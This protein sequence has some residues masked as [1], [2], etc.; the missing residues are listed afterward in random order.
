MKKIYTFL[1]ALT[2]CTCAS[3]A[4]IVT[5]TPAILQESSKNVVLT[6]HADSPLGNQGLAG[7]PASAK[8]YAHI[9]AITNK[10]TST[11]DWKY[12]VADWTVNVDKAQLQYVSP[13]TWNLNI[14]DMR[15]YFGITDATEHVEKIALVFRTSDGNA[16]GKAFGG[17]DI[18]VDVH[19]EGYAMQFVSNATS[20]VVSTAT[21][22]NFTVYTTQAST[23]TLTCNGTTVKT[24]SN[25]TELTTPYTLSAKGS[26]EFKVTATNGSQTLTETKN[27]MFISPSPAGRYPN[28]SPKMGAVKNADGTVT[29]CIAAPNKSSVIIVPSWDDYQVLDKNIMYYHD[30]NNARYFWIT[31][32]GLRDDVYYPYYYIVDGTIRVGDPYAKLVL[33]NYSDKWIN[34][35]VWDDR[36]QYPYDKF[37]DV[38]LAVYRGDMDTDFKF[39]DF[40]IPDPSNLTIYEMLFRDFTGTEGAA[41]GNGTIRSAMKQLWYLKD[42]GVNAVEVMPVMEF[43]GNNSWGYNPNFYFALDKAYGSPRDFKLFVD[44]CHR[45]GIAVIL[46]VVFNQSDGLHPWYQ[47]YDINSNPFYNATAPHDYSVLNDWKQE[48]PLVRQQFKDVL[49]Y[50]LT[51]YNVDGFRF[52]L[53]KGMGTAYPG[54][55]EAA[56]DTR[57]TVMKDLHAAMKAVK[58]NAIHINENLARADEE[59]KMAADGQLNWANVNYSSSAYI[60]GLT[61]NVDLTRFDATKDGGRTALSTV[62]YAESHDEQRVVYEGMTNGASG[63]KGNLPTVLKRAGGL[64]VQMLLNPGPKM[65]WQFGEL[66]NDENTKTQTGNNVDPKVVRWND[67]NDPDRIALHDTYKALA[68]FRKNNP[69]LFGSAATVTQTNFNA[70]ASTSTDNNTGGKSRTIVIKNG[71]YEVVGLINPR[72]AATSIT[73][74]GTKITSANVKR[75]TASKDFNSNPTINAGR[76]Q[77]S[78]PAHGYVVYATGNTVQDSS[79][80][81]DIVTDNVSSVSVMGVNGEIIIEGEYNSAAVYDLSGRAHRMTGLTPGIYIV[82]VDNESFKVR[83]F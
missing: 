14:G 2:V 65:I 53:V 44:A 7:Q 28:G 11:S 13:N 51:V 63:I 27:M 82:K 12:V 70:N 80:V 49:Q 25:A 24:V 71:D 15:T 55:T 6:Y 38:M 46:D 16:E 54:G 68:N 17:G 61:S 34:E 9:G 1:L 39:S 10:S 58:P 36:P 5:T 79:G 50:W 47:M 32:S 8:L 52:D 83:V 75:V 42:L 20:D 35:G 33:D 31:V 45:A 76:L 40:E 74:T 77:V 66:G 21:T 73:V 78:V 56:N 67:I 18:F 26:Y 43:N 81:D 29:F 19:P 69:Q 4:Q 3:F 23:I 30:Y 62:S 41:E 60:K 72:G 37:S 57:V 48:N 64:A 22:V 59:N